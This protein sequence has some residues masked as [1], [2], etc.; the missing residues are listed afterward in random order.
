MNDKNNNIKQNLLSDFNQLKLLLWKQFI[1]QKR[2]LFSL[3]LKL[4]MPIFF[5]II[6]MP[7]RTVIKSDSNNDDI[8]YKSFK[9]ESFSNQL[10][11]YKNS[12]FSYY[13]NNSNQVNNIMKKAASSLNLDFECNNLFM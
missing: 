3:V 13:P 4:A 11:L 9:M 5:A 2:S 8:K 10:I 6:L 7:I 1:I 12:S